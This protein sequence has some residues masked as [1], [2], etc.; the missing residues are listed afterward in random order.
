MKIDKFLILIIL[1]IAGLSFFTYWQFKNLQKTF[2]GVKLPKIEMPKSESLFPQKT[3]YK[4]F[5]SPDGKLKLKYLSD[6]MEI[7]KESFQGE[8]GAEAKVLFFANK[9]KIEKAAFASLIVQE[10]DLEKE[11]S[12]E[13]IVEKMKKEAE[14]KGKME[15]LKLEIK[16]GEGYL[17]AKYVKEAGSVFFSKEKIIL[18]ENKAYLVTIFTLENWWS[19]FEEEA[20]EILGLVQLNQ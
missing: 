4:E 18:G 19:E 8:I 1:S 12:I 2:P 16:N 7:P 20:K 17:T 6:W 13:N 9:F 14:K 15:V 10:L 3:D 5:T 11:T